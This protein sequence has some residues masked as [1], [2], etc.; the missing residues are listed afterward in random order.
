M[1]LVASKTKV[2]VPRVFGYELGPN[3]DIGGPCMFMEMVEGETLENLMRKQGGIWGSQ[4][5]HLLDQLVPLVFELSTLKFD[6]IGRLQFGKLPDTV[7]LVSY[8]ELSAPPFENAFQYL[9]D[10]IDCRGALAELSEVSDGSR[11]TRAEANEQKMQIIATTI[12]QRAARLMKDAQPGPFPLAHMD[13][14]QQ[15]VIVDSACN[16]LAIIDW[17]NAGTRPYEVV[18]IYHCKLFRHKWQRWEGLDWILSYIWDKF[19]EMEIRFCSTP[20]LSMVCKSRMGRLGRALHAPVNPIQFME[21]IG[22][23]IGFLDGEFPIEAQI[24]APSSKKT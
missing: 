7:D 10:R 6:G 5:R 23:L 11:L 19:T 12:Y 18:D 9:E 2:P 14:N 8:N 16:V 4:V 24:I 1:Q 22:E 13:M 15:N 21:Q 20:R 17:E 3:N